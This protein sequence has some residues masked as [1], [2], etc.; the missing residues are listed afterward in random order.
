MQIVRVGPLIRA[1]SSTS[2][3]IWIETFAP[4]T[5]IVQAQAQT[6]ND[7]IAS[8]HVPQTITASA[9]TTIVGGRFFAIIRLQALQPATWYTYTLSFP[10]IAQP[11]TNIQDI[12]MLQCFRTFAPE[13]VNQDNKQELR[14]MYGSCRKWGTPETDVFAA[15]GSWLTEHYEQRDQLWPH[16]LLLIGDQIY[17][18]DSSD[19]LIQQYPQLHDGARTFEDFSLMYEHAWTQESGVQQALAVLPTYMIFDDHEITN[20]WNSEPLWRIKTLKA[21]MEQLL[22]DGLVAY[23]VYQGWGNLTQHDDAAMPLLAIMDAA[24]ANNEDALEA[25]RAAIRADVYQKT[26]LPW[27]YEIATTPAIFVA[28]VRTERTTFLNEKNEDRYASMHIMS[29]SQMDILLNWMRNQQ[30]STTLMVSSVPLLLPPVIGLAEYVM[31]N[32]FLGKRIAKI[33]QRIASNN[34]FDHWPLYNKSWRALIDAVISPTRSQ[35]TKDL[36]VLSGDVHFSYAVEGRRFLASATAPRIYQLVS[37]PIQNMLDAPSERKIHYQGYVSRLFY[38]RLL[39]RILRMHTVKHRTKNIHVNQLFQ[40]TLA[41]LTLQHS[42][43]GYKIQNV[44][45]GMTEAEAQL[46]V[47]A[48]TD[49]KGRE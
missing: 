15:L 27:H 28:N 34:N 49:I 22:V 7:E 48:S 43:H 8:T 13:E 25:L 16:L 14:I 10:S 3:V 39:M 40:N 38:G 18:D 47:I 2:A 37:T 45:F 4:C 31:G 12:S 32:R 35:Q 1:V 20:N 21:G 41:L 9:P 33:Q 5:V 19:D 17:A 42:S 36:I 26:L 29:N 23:W 24:T 46:E 44:Y 30:T 6:N 11:A